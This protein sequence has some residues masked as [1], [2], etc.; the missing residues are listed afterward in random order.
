MHGE[1]RP[2]LVL[3]GAEAFAFLYEE[4]RKGRIVSANAQL[5]IFK[6]I[7]GDK[8][9]NER[10]CTLPPLSLLITRS[11]CAYRMTD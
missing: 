1:C 10:E 7:L 6:D 4:E 9:L 5:Q 2:T 11:C 3:I 8:I